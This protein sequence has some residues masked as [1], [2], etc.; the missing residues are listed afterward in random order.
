MKILKLTIITKGIAD[1]KHFHNVKNIL[2]YIHKHLEE[3]YL[4]YNPKEVIGYQ[5]LLKKLN[6]LKEEENFIK[7]IKE[8]RI[9]I[10]KINVIKQIKN[11][12]ENKRELAKVIE[13]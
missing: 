5:M 3:H 8:S 13:R 11:I 4:E 12:K 1:V 2:Y 6:K 7:V 10:E 9:K